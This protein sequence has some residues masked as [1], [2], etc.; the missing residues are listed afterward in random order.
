MSRLVPFQPALRALDTLLGWRDP[1]LP[2]ERRRDGETRSCWHRCHDGAALIMLVARADE[3]W[4]DEVL[5]GLPERTRGRGQS[6][7]TILWCRVEGPKQLKR[8]YAYRP[9]PNIAVQEGSKRWLIW[10]L[11]RW[12]PYFDVEDRNRKLAY[13]L[14]AVQRFGSPENFALPAP[15]SCAREGRTRPAPVVTRRLEPGTFAPDAL[16][17]R[18]KEPPDRDAWRKTG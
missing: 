4:S 8:A 14:G 12:L 16:T 18:L 15:G 11:D 2:V 6:G 17:R 5:L 10:A 3:L 9:L 13:H 1:W 7:A